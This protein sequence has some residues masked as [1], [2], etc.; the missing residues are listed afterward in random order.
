MLEALF[1]ESRGAYGRRRLKRQLADVGK[2]MRRRRMGRLLNRLGLSCK[3]KRKFKIT[4]EAKSNRPIALPVVNRQFE[5]EQPELYHV[6]DMTDL[7]RQDK[8][9]GQASCFR[10]YC[11]V[12]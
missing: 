5:V 1:E 4:T 2:G 8:S 12:L 10:L 3:T 9:A 11:G 7:A 6:G